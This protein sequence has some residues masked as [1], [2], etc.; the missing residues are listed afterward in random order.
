M[1]VSV[2]CAVRAATDVLSVPLLSEML[3]GTSA[4]SRRSTAFLS[5][6]RNS[7]AVTD[8]LPRRGS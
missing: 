3:I 6:A 1:L 8:L 5:V 2:S 7:S 4:M